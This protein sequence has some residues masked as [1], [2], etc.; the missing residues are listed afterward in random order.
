MRETLLG[1]VA[2]AAVDGVALLEQILDDL[3]ADEAGDTGYGDRAL[4]HGGGGGEGTAHG[5]SLQ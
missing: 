3:R 4:G 1:N 5:G 2:R